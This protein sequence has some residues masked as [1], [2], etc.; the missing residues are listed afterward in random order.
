MKRITIIVLL[1]LSVIFLL[2]CTEAGLTANFEDNGGEICKIEGKPVIRLYSTTTCPHCHWVGDT[3]EKVVN[4][5][6]AQGKI[7]GMHW[8]IDLGDDTLTPEF[9]GVFPT[10]EAEIFRSQN[11]KGFVPKFVFGCKY[12]RIG[13]PFES[14]D[15]LVKE[16][17]EF[18]RVIEL[19]LN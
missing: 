16:E 14:E 19:L 13:N 6:V 4:E 17:A 8:E 10:S 2:G 15:D 7:V 1:V 3:Y 5:Y 11:E 12:E 18:R 9:E